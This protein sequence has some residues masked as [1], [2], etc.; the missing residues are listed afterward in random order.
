[1]ADTFDLKAI[2]NIVAQAAALQARAKMSTNLDDYLRADNEVAVLIPREGLGRGK[3]LE[4]AQELAELQGISSPYVQKAF[5]A[6]APSLE[7]QRVTVERFNSNMTEGLIERRGNQI[8]DYY[9]ARVVQRFQEV[10]PNG[11]AKVDSNVT[12]CDLYFHHLRR[13]KF[14][15]SK[16]E[17]LADMFSYSSNSPSFPLG[18]TVSASVTVYSPLFLELFGDELDTLTKQFMSLGVCPI[19]YR[20]TYETLSLPALESF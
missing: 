3:A 1:M 7:Q 10:F 14:W 12:S 9:L 13:R 11:V 5:N 20:H 6:Y 2:E 4:T 15:L 19:G 17:K 8:R 16:K 18:I